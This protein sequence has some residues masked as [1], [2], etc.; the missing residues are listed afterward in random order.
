MSRIGRAPVAIPAGVTVE[1]KD[2]F[3]TVKGPKGTLTQDI[4]SGITVSIEG[5]VAT[6]ARANDSK[7]LRAKHGLYR[8]LLQNMVNGVTVGYT[9]SLIINGVGYKVAKQGNKVVLNV[10]Y[11]HPIEFAEIDGIKL[12]CPTITEITISGIDKVKVGQVAANIRSIREPEPYHGYGIRYK[13]EVIERKEG[14]T[15]GK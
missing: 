6:L 2:G 11:S 8:A 5:G 4:D 14:K 9:K 3:M 1:V 12:D 13:D 7:E 10:G 15:A